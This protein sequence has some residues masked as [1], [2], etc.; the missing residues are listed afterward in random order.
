MNFIGLD[1]L[2]FR[3]SFKKRTV[4]KLLNVLLQHT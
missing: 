3:K 4:K 2:E 1:I